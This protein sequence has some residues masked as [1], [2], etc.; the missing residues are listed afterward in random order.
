MDLYGT[1][2]VVL[3]ACETGLGKIQRGNGVA[4]LRR[5]FKI[6]GAKNIIMSLWSVPDQETGWLME[7]FYRSYLAGD[8]PAVALNKARSAIRKKLI[9]R[10]GVDQPFYWAAFVL[11]GSSK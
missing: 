9:A 4:G 2:L 6:A 10:D 3:S 1:D 11:E 7:E 5:A 8:D